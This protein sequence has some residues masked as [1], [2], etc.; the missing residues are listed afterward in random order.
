MKKYSLIAVMLLLAGFIY[1]QKAM[2]TFEETTYDFGDIY[3]ED[4]KATHVFK[5]KNTGTS[6]LVVSRVRASCGCTTPT[7]TRSPIEPGK[8]GTITVAYNPAGR[9]NAF[10]KSIAVMS[11]AKDEQVVLLIKGVV[12]SKSAAENHKLPVVIGDLRLKTKSIQMN[13]VYKGSTQIRSVEIQNTSK[14][15]IKPSLQNLPPHITAKVT[16]EE[17]APNQEGQI[18]FTLNTNNCNQWGP[19]QQDVYLVLNNKKV[20]SND[21]KLMVFGNIV[22][23]FSKLSLEDKRKAPI[24]ELST[25]NVNFDVVKVGSKKS[26]KIKVSNKGVDPLEIRRVLNNNKELEVKVD[27]PSVKAGRSTDIELVLDSKNLVP[28]VYK[29]SFTIQTNDP[30]RSIMIVVV[31]W[32]IKK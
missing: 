1:A 27:K 23:N 20:F 31:D 29:K 12:I 18:T 7:W 32:I 14:A 26:Y 5:F 21:Y 19:I 3:E 25:R 9:P 6:P 28:G 17:L 10:T 24:V 30:D 13:N 16:P 8:S 15:N 2:I 4:G 22:E 11:N